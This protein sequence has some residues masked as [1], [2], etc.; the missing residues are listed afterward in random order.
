M[1]RT[2]LFIVVGLLLALFIGGCSSYNNMVEKR[3]NVRKQWQQVEVVYQRRADL[4]P[5]L[6]N[7]VKGVAEFEKSTLTAVVEARAK[8]TQM[9]VDPTKLT[10]EAVAQFEANQGALSSAI[11]R[12]LVVSENYPQL[13]ATENF[14]ALMAQL[15]G[16]ENRISVERKNFNDVAAEYNTYIQKFPRNMFAGMFGF[17]QMGYFKASPGSDKAP[18][19]KF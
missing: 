1:K 9:T 15:E 6:V 16:T 14:T 3:E 4:I 10:P 5:N 13:R 12:L 11:G 2:G 18:E 17:D 7:T 8:A 19:V